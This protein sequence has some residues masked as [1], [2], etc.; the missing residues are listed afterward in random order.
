MHRA[1]M[2]ARLAAG[3]QV[4]AIAGTAGKTTVTG[5]AGYLLAELGADPTVI[6]GGNVLNWQRADATG[7][8]RRGRSNLWVLEADESDRSLLRFTPDWAIV[9]NISKDHFE[10]A[11]VVALFRQFAGQVKLGIICGPGV[12]ELLRGY[13][14]AVLIEVPGLDSSARRLS[15]DVEAT[16][17]RFSSEKRPEAA[18]TTDTASVEASSRR[19]SHEKR[20]EAAS[21]VAID[22]LADVEAT[23][24]RLSA[25]KKRPEAASTQAQTASTSPHFFDPHEPIAKLS[26]NLPHWRQAGATY[27]VTFRTADSLP[28]EKIEQW[29]RERS[30]WLQQ[31][32]EPHTAAE[33][34]EYHALFSERFETWLDTGYGACLLG[35]PD[36]RRIVE[37][38]LRHFD[39]ERYRLDAFVIM[40][41][42]VHVLVAPLG[43][44]RLSEIV[45]SWKSYSAHEI[46]KLSG[47]SGAIWQKE[48]FD[49][50]VRNAEHLE[51][52]RAYIRDNPKGLRNNTASVEAT[53]RRFSSEKRPED[54][55]TTDTASVEATSRRLSSGE[56]RP[57]AASTK[58]VQ[59]PSDKLSPAAAAYASPLPGRHNAE[60]VLLAATLCEQLGFAPEKILQP[61][62]NFLGIQRRLENVGTVRGARIYDD[63]AH[64]PAKI[65]AVWRAVAPARGR[66]FGVWRPHGYGPL[67]LMLRELA[68]AFAAVGRPGDRI[69]I[70]PVFYAGG[71]AS[72]TVSSEL[73]V[74]ALRERGLTAELAPDYDC[75]QARLLAELGA[76]DVILCMGARDPDLPLFARRLAA[77]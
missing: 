69:F 33:R 58:A 18:S 56:K 70:L 2:L 65:A 12:A 26:G 19:L 34:Q 24:R 14:A 20:P 67:A 51:R 9:T 39:G 3:R 4:V 55:S 66:V 25:E 64:N 7:S 36:A 6:N 15:P 43:E 75:L 31:H 49:H 38:T 45:R 72:P 35:Q 77:S 29:I 73:L 52:I 8:V 27:F 53:S 62:K 28:Q 54:A 71:T 40:P 74:S 46:G 37:E 21:T 50:M 60:N 61:L 57:A 22:P 47:Q 17:R 5:L 63:Y 48:Y 59:L 1:E 11:E 41:N 44:H 68:D 42:H 32:S 13:T 23:S 16:A 76:G 30:A 10:L